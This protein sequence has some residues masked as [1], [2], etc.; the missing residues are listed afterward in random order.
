MLR[1]NEAL[2]FRAMQFVCYE[3]LNWLSQIVSPGTSVASCGLE[4][5]RMPSE[6][7]QSWKI[8]TGQQLEAS[9]SSGRSS[10]RLIVGFE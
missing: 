1:D 3:P 2:F 4:H 10:S 8:T 6:S 5:A 9:L 7:L